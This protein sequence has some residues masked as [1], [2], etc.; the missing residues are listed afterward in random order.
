MDEL[1]AAKRD[2]WGGAMVILTA[3][4]LPFVPEAAVGKPVVVV[5]PAWSGDVDEARRSS[6][7]SRRSARSSTWRC[8]SPTPSC[9]PRST[10]ATRTVAQL[11]ERDPGEDLAVTVLDTIMAAAE[12]FPTPFNNII[13]SAMGGAVARV[14]LEDTAFPMRDE[15][16]FFHPL[17]RGADPSTDDAVKAWTKD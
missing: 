7:R 10:R 17:G 15:G 2:E 13:M 3:P 8:R 16:W 14:P 11:L 6:R 4:P 1:N 5:V 9:R 12:A